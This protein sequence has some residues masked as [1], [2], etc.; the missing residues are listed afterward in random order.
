ME[1]QCNVKNGKLQLS[2]GMLQIV[3]PLGRGNIWQVPAYTITGISVQ[4]GGIMGDAVTF[5]TPQGAFVAEWVAKKDLEKLARMIPAMVQQ[6]SY[7]SPDLPRQAPLKKSN[8]KVGWVIGLVAVGIIAIIAIVK[9]QTSPSTDTRKARV[10][11][12][13][14]ALAQGVAVDDTAITTSYD[15]KTNSSSVVIT[16]KKYP[17][18]AYAV[19]SIQVN[20]W[21]V[22]SEIWKAG[23]DLKEVTVHIQNEGK[24]VASC[25]LDAEKEKSFDWDQAYE[26]A[27]NR[28]A[29][30]SVTLDYK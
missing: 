8:K 3:Q 30:S 4:P 2:N 23:L 22:Q 12:K 5:H 11:Q 20:C 17:T 10:E 19:Q 14:L 7:Q 13:T 26:D 21:F 25:T 27:W 24:E 16:T 9:P 1:F 15:E 18:K 29:Y 6:P 28:P